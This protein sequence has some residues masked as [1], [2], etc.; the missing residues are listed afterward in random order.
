MAAPPTGLTRGQLPG[1][2]S[3]VTSAATAFPIP[4][5]RL[6]SPARRRSP[7]DARRPR[8]RTPAPAGPAGAASRSPDRRRRGDDPEHH[9]ARA[10]GC[11]PPRATIRPGRRSPGR[12]ASIPARRAATANANA[13]PSWRDPGGKPTR[14]VAP[15]GRSPAAS[16]AMPRRRMIAALAACSAATLISPLAQRRPTWCR[17]G[18]SMLVGDGLEAAGRERTVERAVH[19]AA[20]HR[21][22]GVHE[23]DTS[24][25]NG[26]SGIRWRSPA[27]A[28]C[29]QLDRIGRDNRA[30]R[31]ARDH[32]ASTSS[33]IARSRSMAR[34]RR[35]DSRLGAL[36]L[37]RS[38]SGA[39]T[40]AA[41]GWARRTRGAACRMCTWFVHYITCANP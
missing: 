23:R 36:W 38:R 25:A 12:S 8:G 40:R 33:R 17:A 41:A 5:G 20:V 19:G 1:G 31:L 32:P 4:S 26:P 9:G 6:R 15:P 10:R 24:V 29:R 34:R 30:S 22:G 3:A 18:I 37:R 21:R 2:A 16:N 28:R 14:I 11:E 35:V 27:P 39:P 13:A 7:R